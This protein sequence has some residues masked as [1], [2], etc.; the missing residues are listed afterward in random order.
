M[1]Y[2]IFCRLE[3]SFCILRET[4]LLRPVPTMPAM[5]AMKAMKGMKAMKADKAMK[6]KPAAAMKKAM[7]KVSIFHT[8]LIKDDCKDP[9][10]PWR[11]GKA[12]RTLQLQEMRECAAHAANGLLAAAQA[13]TSGAYS[14]LAASRQAEEAARLATRA[15]QY[16]ALSQNEHS[17]NLE[18]NPASPVGK[19]PKKNN[20]C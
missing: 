17:A 9:D 19:A 11:N 15:E 3:I 10:D 18:N 20:K 8:T 13:A 12:A 7:K 14:A 4:K 6:R 5:K 2:H 16:G 1:T